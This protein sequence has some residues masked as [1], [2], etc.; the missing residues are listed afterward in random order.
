MQPSAAMREYLAEIYRL[1]EGSPT[2]STTS[3]AERLNVSAPAVPRMLK[4]LKSAGYVKHV[5]YQGVELTERGRIEAL[6]EIRRH[7]ILEVFLVNIMGFS[8]DETHEHAEEMGKGLNDAISQRMAEMTQFPLRC[9]HGEPIPDELGHL[10]DLND[11][12]I[13]NLGVGYKG[14]VSRVR[15]DDPEKLRY[16]ASLGLVPGASFEIV[17]RAPF[18]GPMRLKVNQEEV[19][20]GINLTES[21]WVAPVN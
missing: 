7:R 10:P 8:W 5:P 18:N 19:V 11:I 2:V 4:R 20:L 14:V 13:I 1:Q 15:T 16:F 3:L 17:G 9:P 21:L 6:K 12:S